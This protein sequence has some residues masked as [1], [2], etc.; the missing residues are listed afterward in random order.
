[1]DL[2]HFHK[3]QIDKETPFGFFFFVRFYNN[4]SCVSLGRAH[5]PRAAVAA[6]GPKG[7]VR[8]S[9]PA[10]TDR[11]RNHHD[12]HKRERGRLWPVASGGLLGRRE[13]RGSK[14]SSS[15]SLHLKPPFMLFHQHER[16][17]LPASTLRPRSLLCWRTPNLTTA[18]RGEQPGELGH[19]Q[20]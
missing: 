20:R 2:D 10:D 4:V 8:K 16:G 3:W 19:T 12:Q 14:T 9:S 15:S 1:M 11:H 13:G 6:R 17:D 7:L 5:W 18:A